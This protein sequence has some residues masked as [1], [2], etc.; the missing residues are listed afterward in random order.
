MQQRSTA[1]CCLIV[2]GYAYGAVVMS[3][4][5]APL[6]S[7]QEYSRNTF[8]NSAEHRCSLINLT[9]DWFSLLSLP[10]R[11]YDV[12]IMSYSGSPRLIYWRNTACTRKL[13]AVDRWVVI[14]HS[15]RVD[16]QNAMF[17]QSQSLTRRC[18][19]L[20]AREP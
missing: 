18:N 2:A 7:V 15:V 13:C 5:V 8:I 11:H 20:P 1:C 4:K 12:I 6:P 9:M 14:T 16:N 19:A 17:Q 10:V 3:I